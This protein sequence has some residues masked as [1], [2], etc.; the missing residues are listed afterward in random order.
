MVIT[1]AGS[2]QRHHRHN[3]TSSGSVC[4]PRR[5]SVAITLKDRLSEPGIECDVVKVVIEAVAEVRVASKLD[6][7]FG[8][9]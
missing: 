6:L 5:P 8:R 7:L 4:P 1:D 9:Q 3:T 2:R